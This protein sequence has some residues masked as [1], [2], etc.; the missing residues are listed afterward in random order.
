[1]ISLTLRPPRLW[2][3]LMASPTADIPHSPTPAAGLGTLASPA[4][5]CLTRDFTKPVLALSDGELLLKVRSL[6][7]R[8][9]S[10]VDLVGPSLIATPVVAQRVGI[11]G[12]V[13]EARSARCG[14][15]AGDEVFGATDTALRRTDD[16]RVVVRASMMSAKPRRLD[17]ERSA[18]LSIAAT[19]AWQMLFGIGR[20]DPGETVLVIGAEPLVGALALQLAAAFGVRSTGVV[21]CNS[22]S[23]AGGPL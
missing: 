22:A 10:T 15:V 14:F 6:D 19:C 4:S 20:I 11:A 13:E 21:S 23:C 17:F 5:S 7:D 18:S 1:M 8:A 3:S 9:Y 12:I 16:G 2:P